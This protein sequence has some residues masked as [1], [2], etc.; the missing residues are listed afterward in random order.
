METIW[1]EWIDRRQREAKKHLK[2]IEK[3]LKKS[4]F[5]VDSYLED[6]NPYVFVKSPQKT[7]LSFEG[8]R[9]YE[10]GEMIAYRVQREKKTEPFGKAYLLDLEEM[11]N[12][13]M[14]ENMKENDAGKKVIESVALEVKKFFKKSGEAEQELLDSEGGGV[15]LNAAGGSD[16][17]SMVMNKM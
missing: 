16:Y 15:I 14:S 3:L 6:E 12:D 9:I 8:I 1:N 13:Y 5:E 7:K 17:S 4:N 11:F 2:L 10:I